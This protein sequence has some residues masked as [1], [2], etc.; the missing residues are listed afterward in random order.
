MVRV[1]FAALKTCVF[2]LRNLSSSIVENINSQI[3]PYLFL[4]RVLKGKFLYLLQFYLNT[5]KYLNSRVKERK[6]KSPIEL[7]TGK[8]YG[9]WLDILF[10]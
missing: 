5:R 1:N 9:N 3:R 4:K 6:G 8:N 7:L 10:K 2:V